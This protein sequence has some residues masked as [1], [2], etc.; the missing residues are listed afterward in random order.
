[1]R[2]TEAIAI[3]LGAPPDTPA[4]KAAMERGTKVHQAIDNIFH[5]HPAD[6]EGIEQYDMSVRSAV[7]ILVDI[8]KIDKIPVES[9]VEIL[10]PEGY[11]GH[12][13]WL[14]KHKIIEIKSAWGL[15]ARR[16]WLRWY[17]QLGAYA[18]GAPGRALELWIVAPDGVERTAVN[19]VM[20]A[21]GW[22]T[23]LAGLE[24]EEE[25]DEV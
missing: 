18:S 5:G 24:I 6:F 19:P 3:V 16:P 20:A 22:R 1:M 23:V 8:D 15:R 21:A 17:A 25:E 9:E 2:V 7:E 4:V 14:S 10:T 12:I 13:D 11:T